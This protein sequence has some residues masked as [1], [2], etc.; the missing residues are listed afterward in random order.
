MSLHAAG[1][2]A[3]GAN[4]PRTKNDYIYL[5]TLPSLFYYEDRQEL[6]QSQFFKWFLLNIS[7]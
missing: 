7:S 2:T 3:R 5:V 1:Q 4:D 6:A